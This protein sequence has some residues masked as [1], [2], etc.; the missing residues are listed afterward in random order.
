WGG[1]Y[2]LFGDPKF[3]T[4]NSGSAPVAAAAAA[5]RASL[6][7]V[8]VVVPDYAIVDD[9]GYLHADIPGG[10]ALVVT[11]MPIVPVYRVRYDLAPGVQVQDVVLLSRTDEVVDAGPVLP[12]AAVGRIGY[13]DPVLEL[14]PPVVP[15]WWPEQDFEWEVVRTPA[16]TT[17][18]LT[19]YPFF[20][21][22]RTTEISFFRRYA[23]DVQTAL[24][25]AGIAD[26]ALD[27]AAYGPGEAVT[28]TLDLEDTGPGGDAVVEV[29]V[30]DE[31][32]GEVVAALY[33]DTLVGLQGRAAWSGVWDPAGVGD[34]YYR[35]RA[36]LRDPS[37]ELLDQ[38]V[39]T[40]HI[41]LPDATLSGFVT[42]PGPF[43]PGD[44]VSLAATLTNT[45]T[46]ELDGA[47][48]F[49]VLDPTG[50]PVAELRQTFAGF[51]P[52]TVRH[53]G[54]SWDTAGVLEGTYLAQAFVEYDGGASPPAVAVVST[55]PPC[56]GDTDGDGDVDGSD[57][58]AA[59][60]EFGTA[61]TDGCAADM[62]GDGDVDLDDLAGIADGFGR[63]GCP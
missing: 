48:V 4:V 46:T 16:G 62:D 23:F 57:L 17:L 47:V 49:R 6:G 29:W 8:D 60:A 53:F 15:D 1:I 37:G 10:D 40:L 54:D 56:P 44:L 51:V 31:G 2:H 55:Y 27:K 12:V 32:D 14:P 58:A 42:S 50:A 26:L 22:H 24:S 18:A 61:C 30:E 5:P 39:E 7:V 20:Y 36:T 21:N 34:G 59:A 35:V 19:V 13:D 41:G 43:T 52:G 28:V 33:L 45:G 3:G 9:A 25:T 63:T 38:A 11:G